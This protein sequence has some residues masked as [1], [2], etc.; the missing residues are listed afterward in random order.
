MCD[1]QGVKRTLILARK[2]RRCETENCGRKAVKLHDGT[3]ERF[4]VRCRRKLV[5]Q[6]KKDGYL[7]PVPRTA[8][9][10]DDEQSIWR[11]PGC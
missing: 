5:R 1:L 7:Q 9:E 2:G 8:W 3:Q 11:S 10:Q 4:C 6:M